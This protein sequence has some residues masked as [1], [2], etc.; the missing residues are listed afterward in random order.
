MFHDLIIASR[1]LAAL[2]RFKLIQPAHLL[3]ALTA[4]ETGRDII[5]KDGYDIH[6]L[7]ACLIRMF[8]EHAA[9]V[10]DCEGRAEPSDLFEQCLET[11]INRDV[12]QFEDSLRLLFGS[13]VS[14]ASQ[15]SYVQQALEEANMKQEVPPYIENEDELFP[16]LDSLLEEDLADVEKKSA[17]THQKEEHPLKGFDPD[18]SV[19]PGHGTGGMKSA[20]QECMDNIK[21]S[22]GTTRN[23]SKLSKDM[24]E[25]K[26]AMLAAQRNLTELARLGKLDPVVGREK[27]IDHMV[28]ILM[29]RRKPNIILV[30]EPGVGKSALVEGLA[31]RLAR[32]RCPDPD[33]AERLVKEVSLTAMVAGSRYRGDFEARMNMMI[34][35]ATEERSIIF[36]DEIHTL[37][38]SGSVGQRG[39][40]G[41]NILKPA[42]ARDGLSII[43]ATTPDEALILKTDKALMRRFELIYIDEPLREQM[44]T[45]LAGA[46]DQFLEKHGVEISKEM[47]P[48]LLDFGDRYLQHRRNPDRTFDLLDLSAVS[49]RLRGASEITEV[50]MRHG[51]RR[52][53]GVLF[54]TT[55]LKLKSDAIHKYISRKV[56]G[57]SDALTRLSQMIEEIK[58]G[59]SLT[60]PV[61][62]KGPKGLGKTHTASSVA[63]YFGK[64]VVQIHGASMG[65]DIHEI[66]TKVRFHLEVDPEAVLS[67]EVPEA[68]DIQVINEAIL[69]LI[70]KEAA[71]NQ[72]ALRAP[73]IFLI[74]HEDDGGP[75]EIGFGR[76]RVEQSDKHPQTIPF[77]VP[78]GS[79][80]EEIVD[81]CL[82]VALGMM[83]DSGLETA[84]FT[85]FKSAYKKRNGS[86]LRSFESILTAALNI[87]AALE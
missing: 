84:E 52:L 25:A 39:M 22:K 83:Q 76:Q 4:N 3:H 59:A 44:E 68:R 21:S 23:T 2:Y 19:P 17:S 43:G 72:F 51:V 33:L 32:G 71:A 7:R 13:I 46:A 45:I 65:L 12:K 62:L 1:R 54:G 48:R 82:S 37:V 30:A 50:D 57:Q 36:M 85:Q 14:I 87:P 73:L 49:A 67:I 34:D 74:A 18:G 10:R 26:T 75:V 42:L 86:A 79:D 56:Y 78:E 16:D 31:T 58:S 63:A 29:R 55:D 41:V 24:E 77:S 9:T 66:V 5:S 69:N 38:G 6:V 60:A 81:Y 8:K 15:D 64:K 80:L 27:E 61:I 20:F 53:G 35:H 70:K 28:E 11:T 47:Q 40:D